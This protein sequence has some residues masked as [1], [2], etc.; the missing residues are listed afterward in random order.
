LPG[1]IFSDLWHVAFSHHGRP[2]TDVTAEVIN[3]VLLI[4]ILVELVEPRITRCVQAEERLSA[5][6]S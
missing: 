2:L 4:F 5:R 3:E 1:F 6:T